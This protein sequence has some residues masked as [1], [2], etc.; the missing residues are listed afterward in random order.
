MNQ[1]INIKFIRIT[2]LVLFA[3]TLISGCSKK[4]D[5]SK[6]EKYGFDNVVS[7][8]LI[9]ILTQGFDNCTCAPTI[10]KAKYENQI[11]YY[12]RYASA[13]CDGIIAPTLYDSQGNIVAQMND[14]FEYSEKVSE[15][16]VIYRCGH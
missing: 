11:V 10:F 14:V 15:K 2:I 16:E 12:F 6:R 4:D 7:D 8:K 9:D 3:F 1:S 5:L 13:Y